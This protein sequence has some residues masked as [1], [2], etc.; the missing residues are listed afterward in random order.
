MAEISP[1]TQAV[2]DKIL[3]LAEEL[4]RG[5]LDVDVATP[6]SILAHAPGASSRSSAASKRKASYGGVWW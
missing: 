3:L 6:S 2:W 5:V 1:R 4:K